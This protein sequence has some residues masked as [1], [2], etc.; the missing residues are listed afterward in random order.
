M[1]NENSFE[2]ENKPLEKYEIIN[3]TPDNKRKELMSKLDKEKIIK[4][5]ESL[6]QRRKIDYGSFKEELKSKTKDLSDVEITFLIY[7]WIT[8]NISY[9]TKNLMIDNPFIKTSPKDTFKIGSTIPT[10]YSRLFRDLCLNLCVEAQSI[11]GYSKGINYAENILNQN[12]D[13]NGEKKPINHQYN[14]VKLNNNWHFID[15]ALGAGYI[16]KNFFFIRSY[17]EFYFLT[18]P[19]ELIFSHFPEE[20][21]WQLLPNPITEEEFNKGIKISENFFKCGFDS[22]NFD[23]SNYV[24]EQENETVVLEYDN[25][26][27]NPNIKCILKLNGNEDLSNTVKI[28]QRANLFDIELEFKKSGVY[29]LEILGRNGNEA[30]KSMMVY[31]FEHK[32]KP[33]EQ[34]VKEN[35]KGNAINASST[36]PYHAKKNNSKNYKSNVKK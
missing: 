6:P 9:D 34:N 12:K 2:E 1:Q 30:F 23:K 4:I 27:Y 25:E 5:T 8:H 24:I 7:Y 19:S 3:P 22:T 16:T 13:E 17:N 29:K 32:E 21:K 14:A 28:S 20:E 10:G 26:N 15:T 11:N 18:K 33:K 35:K 36:G 31:I